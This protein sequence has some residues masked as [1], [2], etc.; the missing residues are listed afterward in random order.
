MP[1]IAAASTAMITVA[2]AGRLCGQHGEGEDTRH[3][4]DDHDAFQCDVDDAGVLTEH[5]AQSD[6]HQ[7]DAIQQSILDEKQHI[8]CPPSWFRS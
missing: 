2:K 3:T 5:T 8:T 1:A 4:A 6:Q 7:H